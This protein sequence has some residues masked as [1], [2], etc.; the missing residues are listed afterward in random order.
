MIKLECVAKSSRAINRIAKVITPIGLVKEMSTALHLKVSLNHK[1]A[2][3]NEALCCLIV[4]RF[5]AGL[6]LWDSRLHFQKM[7]SAIMLSP[8]E[9]WKFHRLGCIQ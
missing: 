6:R 9:K 1:G 7:P 8:A 4:I 5:D 2:R 3:W